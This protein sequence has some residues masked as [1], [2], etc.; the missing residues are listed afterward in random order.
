MR[1]KYT[2]T[3]EAGTE[4]DDELFKDVDKDDIDKVILDYL[5]D[6]HRRDIGDTC[7]GDDYDYE[8]EINSSEL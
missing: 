3:I 7:D 6:K 4:I 8:I 1:V 2:I 5:C